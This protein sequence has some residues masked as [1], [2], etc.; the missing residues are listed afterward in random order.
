MNHVAIRTV[1][2][3]ALAIVGWLAGGAL[4]S[5][6]FAAVG[7]AG[8]WLAA[9]RH[10]GPLALLPPV[11]EADGQRLPARWCCHECGKSW[12]AA[13]L[14]DSTAPVPRFAG[15]DEKKATEAAR[16]A[17]D[18]ERRQR[19]LAVRRAGLT[20]RSDAA[21]RPAATL[22]LERAPRPVAIRSR[23]IG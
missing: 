3:A 11:V 9:C 13:A 17:V 12:P 8:L 6:A 1:T 2:V 19:E 14:E 5:L 10:P 16:R 20:P 15:F 4:L 7:A 18:L 23:R 21:A 22:K